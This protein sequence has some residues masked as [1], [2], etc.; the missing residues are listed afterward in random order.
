[1]DASRQSVEQFAAEVE[2][3]AQWANAG[4]DSGAKAVHD[5]LV[6]LTRLYIAALEMPTRQ[7]TTDEPDLEHLNVSDDEW[8]AVLAHAARLGFDFYGSIFDPIPVPPQEPCVGS[9]AD[10]I[11]DIY[12]DVVTGL[13]MHRAG[14][15]QEALHHWG[16]LFLHHWGNHAT[17][18]I[19][20][21]HC[22]LEQNDPEALAQ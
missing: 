13:R 12:R 21:M 2:D 7:P 19:R 22:W 16:F 5:G 15:S 8:K 9:L 1:M 6:R 11:A 10:D 18:A 20:A 4:G 14:H 3:F 17:G